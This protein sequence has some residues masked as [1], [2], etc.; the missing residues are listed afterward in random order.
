MGLGPDGCWSLRSCDCDMFSGS[1][2]RFRIMFVC[3]NRV[4]IDAGMIS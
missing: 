3:W 4:G 2:S 1:W